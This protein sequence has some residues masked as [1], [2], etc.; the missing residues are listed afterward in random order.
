[1]P[2]NYDI[3]RV[4]TH[5]KTVGVYV[6]GVALS[7]LILAWVMKLWKADL[8]VPFNYFGDALFYGFVVKGTVENGWYLRNDA[9]GAPAGL[10]M[11]DYPLAEGLNL[12]LIKALGLIR[13]EYGWVLNVFFLLTFPLTTVTSL[14]ALLQWKISNFAALVGS[15]L[16]TFI[17]FH[18]IRGEGHLVVSTYYLVPLAIT[19]ALWLSLGKLYPGS[20]SGDKPS[21]K[22]VLR[23]RKVALSV[24]F[25]LLFSSVG[26]GYYAF[27]SSFFILF[28]GITATICYRT[29]Q[30]LIIGIILC[31]VI[32]IGLLANVAPHLIHFKK[33]GSVNVTQRS[34]HEAET[35]G[36]KITQMILPMRKHRVPVFAKI[37]ENY[38]SGP[39]VNENRASALGLV[40]VTG[41]MILVIWFLF[42]KSDATSFNANGTNSIVHHLSLM[43]IAA[44]LLGTVGGFSALFALFISPQIRAYNRLSVYISFLSVLTIVL[45]L[46]NLFRKFRRT[47]GAQSAYRALL[48]IILSIGLLDQTS[49]QFVPDYSYNKNDFGNDE[50][51]VSKIEAVLPP[52]SMI[53]QMPYVPFPENPK[54]HDMADYELL[55]GYL[56]SKTLRWSYGAM[57]GREG[58]L[59][60][61]DVHSRPLPELLQMIAFAGFGG[62]YLD[63]IGFSDK[64]VGT[65]GQLTNLLGTQPLISRNGRLI[66]FDLTDFV[67]KLKHRYSNEQW[68]L[69]SELAKHPLT[70][71]WRGGFSDLEV[72]GESKWRWS[73]AEGE[74]WINN[75]LGR[76]RRIHLEMELISG[77]T[78]FANMKIESS[79]FVDRLLVN[80]LG[81]KYARSFAVQPGSY[82]IRF[83]CDAQRVFAPKDE[84]TLVFKVINFKW[85]EPD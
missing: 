47:R 49:A 56:H 22:S 76:E 24:M 68:A 40:G 55:R 83:S 78:E 60:L 53:F 26:Q 13:N 33:H 14:W 46:E 82:V 72:A 11:H 16:Y 59:W 80:N 67:S 8:S 9:L 43:N 2:L 20:N 71:S 38:T 30:P 39:L 48:V 50:E 29:V 58:D 25:C 64:A 44:V 7:V 51:F 79:A 69:Q 36:L 28:A 17:P 23:N 18:F 37:A 42:M 84:R 63:R 6:I 35:Y 21:V 10:R 34:A 41:F 32:F 5:L 75:P 19:V 31:G 27:F 12:L 1:M 54:V 57:K 66:F 65:E 74:L 15:L 85:S 70:F 4:R 77:H 61:G 73:S 81:V 3:S 52:G 62:I 45:L